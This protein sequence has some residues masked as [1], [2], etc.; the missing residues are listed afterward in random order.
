MHIPFV[1]ISQRISAQAYRGGQDYRLN[2]KRPHSLK[3]R[4]VEE[5]TELLFLLADTAGHHQP[6]RSVPEEKTADLYAAAIGH[7]DAA[8]G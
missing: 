2:K 5:R 8:I 1:S 4:P 3:M 6:G 7:R